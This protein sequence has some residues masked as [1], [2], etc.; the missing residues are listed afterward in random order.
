M[1]VTQTKNEDDR[2]C[3]TTEEILM[4]FRSGLSVERIS[5]QLLIEVD[6]VI[7]VLKASPLARYLS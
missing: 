5:N 7:I 2:R 4:L 1:I 3:Q 6:R